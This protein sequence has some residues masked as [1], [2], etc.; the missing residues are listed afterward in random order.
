MLHDPNNTNELFNECIAHFYLIGLQLKINWKSSNQSV[1]YVNKCDI[2][3]HIIILIILTF[4]VYKYG[5]VVQKLEEIS[6][7]LIF[8]TS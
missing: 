1:V 7:T 4:T 2:I 5:K 3:I 8:Q 6:E